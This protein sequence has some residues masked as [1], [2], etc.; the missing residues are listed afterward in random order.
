M[1]YHFTKMI[2]ITFLLVILSSNFIN[3]Q[4]GDAKSLEIGNKWYYFVEGID[5]FHYT[6]EVIGTATINNIKYAKIYYSTN[7]IVYE[8]ADSIR[9]YRW[10][11]STSTETV[12]VDFSLNVGDSLNLYVVT[13]K[14]A[15][16]LW[17]RLLTKICLYLHWVGLVDYTDCYTEWIGKTYAEGDGIAINGYVETLEA[18]LIE[19]NI[20]GDSTLVEVEK[21]DFPAPAQFRLYQNYPNPFN[22]TT[23]II[24]EIPTAGFV[25]IKI[26]D[27]LGR[28]IKTINYGYKNAGRYKVNFDGNNLSSGVYFYQVQFENQYKTKRMLLIK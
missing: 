8:R 3:G 17:G 7:Q 1:N 5:S 18:A 6:T 22:P 16:F 4:S 11:P 13:S 20:Y 15:I 2:L 21:Q 25:K 23:K 10:D 24:F 9:I 27:V 19:G 26:Y 12:L 28:S 14:G